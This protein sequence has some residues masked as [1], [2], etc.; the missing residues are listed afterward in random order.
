MLILAGGLGTRLRSVVPELPKA[1]APIGGRPFLAHLLEQLKEQGFQHMCLAVGYQSQVIKDY[2]QDGTEL[3]VHLTYSEEK[4]P[5]GTGGGMKKASEL[6]PEEFLVLNGDSYL[7]IDFRKLTAFHTLKG[8]L[9]T[10]ALVKAQDNMRYG[11]VELD[12]D[13]RII[14]FKEKGTG[15][16]SL[17]FFIAKTATRNKKNRQGDF[18]CQPICWLCRNMPLTA[19]RL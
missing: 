19:V 17:D 5:L 18:S 3:G 14:S 6:L 9:I 13:Q 15:W 10:M 2:F 7:Q 8:A 4:H 11:K 1:M 16:E 12:V